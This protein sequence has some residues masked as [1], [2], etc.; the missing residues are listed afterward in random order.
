M[1]LVNNSIFLVDLLI[2]F[3]VHVLS[4]HFITDTHG[5]KK[6]IR[7]PLPCSLTYPGGSYPN[8]SCGTVSTMFT[9]IYFLLIEKV[10][11]DCRNVLVKLL[12]V[13]VCLWSLHFFGKSFL[14]LVLF[15]IIGTIDCWD[16]TPLNV[17]EVKFSKVYWED[18]AEMHVW[19]D[20]KW[21]L[22]PRIYMIKYP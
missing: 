11:C 10:I 22:I 19:T 1:I 9:Y 8:L 3:F 21:K 7:T 18:L 2:I 12:C 13:Y 16:I 20:P 4:T 14:F 5:F 6:I 15:R 17:T